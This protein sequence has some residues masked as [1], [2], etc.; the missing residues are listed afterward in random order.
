M[1]IF[2]PLHLFD[3]C[4]HHCS[5]FSSQGFILKGSYKKLILEHI[6]KDHTMTANMF[7]L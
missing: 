7:C 5:N 6:V 1:T 3:N 4:T 2:T